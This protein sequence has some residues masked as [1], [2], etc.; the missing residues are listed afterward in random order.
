MRLLL[1]II[2]VASYVSTKCKQTWYLVLDN[3]ASKF[4]VHVASKVFDCEISLS[5]LTITNE[6]K[7]AR[8]MEEEKLKMTS[9]FKRIDKH[10]SLR[11]EKKRV[12]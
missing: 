7:N 1:L 10:V 4:I 6:D 5:H 2:G 9:L 12:K 3:K 11:L 8:K